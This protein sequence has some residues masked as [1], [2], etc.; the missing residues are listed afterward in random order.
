MHFT[1]KAASLPLPTKTEQV[2]LEREKHSTWPRA[3]FSFF[4]SRSPHLFNTSSYYCKYSGPVHL[5]CR[6]PLDSTPHTIHPP[7]STI[8]PRP[9]PE[10]QREENEIRPLLVI[11]YRPP[12]CPLGL[13]HTPAAGRARPRCR[14]GASCPPPP[15]PPPLLALPPGPRREARHGPA[16]ASLPRSSRPPSPSLRAGGRDPRTGG[17]TRTAS[18]AG[19]AAPLPS[20]VARTRV[21]HRPLTPRRKP[22][23]APSTGAQRTPAAAAARA[24]RAPAT[25]RSRPT[26]ARPIPPRTCLPACRFR[27]REE[28]ARRDTAVKR[29]GGA[30]RG[31]VLA[32]RG[33]VRRCASAR[34]GPLRSS[35]PP[36]SPLS[37]ARTGLYPAL[38]PGSPRRGKLA[39][40]TGLQAAPPSALAP[41]A[42][43]SVSEN[44]SG[45]GTAACARP[46]A[47]PSCSLRDQIG[48]GGSSRRHF[49]S[50]GTDFPGRGFLWLSAFNALCRLVHPST[51]SCFPNRVCTP[52]C[53]LRALPR[54]FTRSCVFQSYGVSNPK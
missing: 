45:G 14:A 2:V 20:E 40:R 49:S 7:V 51:L 19:R 13:G 18:G 31:E 36:G 53:A 24:R 30:G 5:L 42:A 27:C 39:P 10:T 44:A 37:A 52:V 47:R 41:S 16:P 25:P 35:A 50:R 22:T 48:R 54:L 4:T 8:T 6:F 1:S 29:A 38:V 43:F 12:S 32:V 15:S 34:P 9:R 33:P 23:F 46:S 11:L 17:R 26:P 21:P 3:G 28:P